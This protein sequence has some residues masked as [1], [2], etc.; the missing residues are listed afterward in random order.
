MIHIETNP[1]LQTQLSSDILEHAALAVLEHQSADGD[2][3]IVLTDER[4][5]TN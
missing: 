1:T 3:S 5:C 4:N 2:L